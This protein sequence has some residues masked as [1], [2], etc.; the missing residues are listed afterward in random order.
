MA[1]G[2]GGSGV[3]AAKAH[4]LKPLKKV[5]TIILMGEPVITKAEVL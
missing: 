1:V 4:P 2:P 3:R 5:I